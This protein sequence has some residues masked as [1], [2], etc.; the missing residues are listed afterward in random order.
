VTDGVLGEVLRL[1]IRTQRLAGSTLE[2]AVDVVSLLT[3]VQAQESGHPFW[4]LGMRTAGLGQDEVKAELD[5]GTYLRTHILRPTWHYVA[6][7]DLRWIQAVTADRVQRLNGTIYRQYGLDRTRLD[8]AC[9]TIMDA[10]RGGRYQTRAEL[11]RLL[12]ANGVPLAYLVMN[13]ELE[14]VICSGPMRGAQQTYALTSE[15]VPAGADGSGDEVE[16]ARRFVAGHGPVSARDFARWSSLTLTR[17]REAFDALSDRCERV[18]VAGETL[19]LSREEPPDGIED[20][21]LLLPLYDE[22]T[23]TYPGTGFPV[24]AGHPHP[25]AWDELL[26]SVVVRAV[27]IGSWRRTIKGATMTVQVSLASDVPAADRRLVADAAE[28]LASFFEK[29]AKLV[30]E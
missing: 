8:R 26:G 2:R 15:R 13:A 22:A 17:S 25:S 20:R 14:A 1:R 21:A 19:W 12:D 4:S 23:L 3:C 28:S 11:G 5:A 27:N 16:L 6:A 29:M 30:L 10:L 7:A 9:D 18:E 24:A